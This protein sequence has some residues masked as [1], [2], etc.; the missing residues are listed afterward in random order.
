[1]IQQSDSTTRRRQNFTVRT[2]NSRPPRQQKLTFPFLQLNYLSARVCIHDCAVIM[3][4]LQLQ[5]FLI[6]DESVGYSF[7]DSTLKISG[8]VLRL[9]FYFQITCCF[10]LYLM[11]KVCLYMLMYVNLSFC[12]CWESINK[13]VL[14]RINEYINISF[15]CVYS[16]DFS[17]C[18]LPLMLHHVK[19][20]L[21]QNNSD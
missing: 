5:H 8:Q 3:Y 20:K 13:M 14:S 15:L 7:I 1:M 2:W 18:I 6:I 9:R 10:S 21:T 17:F 16:Y 11:H 4:L 12:Y 19:S